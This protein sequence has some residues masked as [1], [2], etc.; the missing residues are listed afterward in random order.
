MNTFN[1]WNDVKQQIDSEEDSLENFSNK[2]DIKDIEVEIPPSLVGFLDSTFTWTLYTYMLYPSGFR[3]KH[4]MTIREKM[5]N[6]F[7]YLTL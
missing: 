6:I 7:Y 4:G 3:V 2:L 1:V 5:K